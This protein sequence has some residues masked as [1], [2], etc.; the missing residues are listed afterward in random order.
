MEEAL[1]RFQECDLK[2]ASGLYKA[3]IK[4]EWDA[5]AST[6]KY[7][8]DLTKE[9]RGEIVEFLEKL[10]QRGKWP[11]QACTTMFFL[12]PKN[13]TSER[14]IPLMPTLIRWWEALGTPAQ[15]RYRVDLG[16]TDGR[17]GGAQQTVWEILMEIKRFNCRAGEEDLGAVALVLDL[18]KAFERASLRVVR[19]WATHFGFPRKVLRVLCADFEHQRRA[20]F[21]GCVAEPLRTITAIVPGSEWSCLFLRIVLQDAFSE[22]AKNYPSLKL[23]VFVD[24][25]TALLMVK[26]K[27]VAEM[28]KKSDEKAERRS[29]ENGLKL[30]VTENGEE[31]KS[32]MIASSGFLENELSEFSK[33][34]G[35]TLADSV[36][37]LGVDLRTR[38]KRLRVER[39]SEEE[40]SVR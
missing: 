17:S 10:E 11:Q 33:E 9:T 6:R 40:K 25:I 26:N 7:L 13:V 3:K 23:R 27:E 34:E 22:V 1:P 12:T 37:T 39:K 2:K 5:T 14:P 36:E 15:Q 21:E 19:A 32:K 29:G 31:G 30:S 38:V 18:A 28:A 35:E 16:A 20:Q 4:Q 8:L 24:D